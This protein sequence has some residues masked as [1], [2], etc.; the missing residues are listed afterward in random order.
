MCCANLSNH[1]VAPVRLHQ[2]IFFFFLINLNFVSHFFVV[3]RMFDIVIAEHSMAAECDSRKCIA[4][5]VRMQF[6]LN[7]KCNQEIGSDKIHLILTP[8]LLKGREK[9]YNIC[10]TQRNVFKQRKVACNKQRLNIDYHFRTQTKKNKRQQ[11][12]KKTKCY[13]YCT[14]IAIVPFCTVHYIYGCSVPLLFRLVPFFRQFFFVFIHETHI[15]SRRCH[16]DLLFLL[17]TELYTINTNF[18][19]HLEIVMFLC[20]LLSVG[21]SVPS[22]ILCA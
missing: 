14:L 9:V 13:P 7:T 18:L 1:F 17:K 10:Q 8:H 12:K 16:G 15:K 22:I 6:N 2:T 11:K 4:V 19:S 20:T 3:V 5:G 21:V